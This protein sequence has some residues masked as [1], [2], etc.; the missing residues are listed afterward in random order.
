LEFVGEAGLG[1]VFE[2]VAVKADRPMP[3]RTFVHNRYRVLKGRG[4]VSGGDLGR[5]AN[6]AIW[7]AIL[8]S[9]YRR[10]GR[11]IYVEGGKVPGVVDDRWL[12]LREF[13]SDVMPTVVRTPESFAGGDVERAVKD[14]VDRATMLYGLSWTGLLVVP[15]TSVV[16]W[17]PLNPESYHWRYVRKIDDAYAKR[18]AA[19]MGRAAA[20][21]A[22][23]LAKQPGY[24][25][26][27]K[28]SLE[29]YLEK[30]GVLKA[31][32]AL[33]VL[34]AL[35][36]F[37]WAAVGKRYA[38]DAGAWLA[39]T[40]FIFMTAGLGGRSIIA[41]HLLIT[42]IYEYLVLLS[43]AVVMYFLIFYLRTRG[44][45][46]GVVVM[47]VAFL[48]VAIASLF[49]ADVEGQLMPALQS[50]WLTVHVV[51]TCLG[52]AAF[53]V[54]FAAALLRLFRSDGAGA[55]TRFPSR[56]RLELIEYRAIALGYPLFAVGALA[57]GA[58]WAQKVWSVWWS[59][60]PKETASLVVFLVAT[61]YLHARRVRGWQGARAAALAIMV[62]AAAAFT[63]FAN[64]IFGGRHSFGP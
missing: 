45:F 10:D 15:G 52:E 12:S 16:G 7:L 54:A 62:F 55:G 35:F 43:W 64:L 29:V 22:R 31:G 34:S 60:D 46:L 63:L 5:D 42:G 18:D 36:F 28:L 39:F 44:A 33:Y 51:L 37:V 1:D 27:A 57:A 38:A 24:P 59:W 6:A 50:R 25:S 48:L 3:W 21:L 53:A 26:R 58:I 30:F 40:G 56:D 49:P 61:A 47:P 14:L 11:L 17:R 4:D 8:D 20:A 32:F 13:E 19:A 9:E 23:D 41:G 2:R